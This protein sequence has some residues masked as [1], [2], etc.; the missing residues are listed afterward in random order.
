MKILYI[1]HK[2]L[3]RYFS[4][5]EIYTYSLCR[6]MQRRGHDVLVFCAEDVDAGPDDRIRATDDAYDGIPVHRIFFNRRKTP[7]VVRYSYDNPLVADHCAWFLSLHQPDVVHATSFINVSAAVVDAA[8][9]FGC[10]MLFTATDY[11]CFCPKSIL[12]NHK[13][14][15]CTRPDP[16]ECLAC[17]IELSSLQQRLLKP[18]GISAA[19]TARWCARVSR[20]PVL[21]NNP[22]LKG[23]A[24][25]EARPRYLQ[26]QMHTVDLVIAPN[27]F[28]YKLFLEF[29]VA[30]GRVIHSIYGLN[31]E[32]IHPA[33]NTAANGR[34]R[35]AYIGM[36]GALKGVEL[37]LRSFRPL[38]ASNRAS[39]AVYG[40]DSHFPRYVRGLKQIAQDCPSIAFRGTFPPDRLGE[41]LS[42]I[43][44]LVVP[45]LWYENAPLVIQSAFAAGVPVVG[46]DVPGIAELVTHEANGLLFVRGNQ[47]SLAASLQRFIDEPELLPRLRSGIC[48]PKSIAENGEELEQQYLRLIQNR[49][50]EGKG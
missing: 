17:I 11:W 41:V 36:L 42:E 48:P 20:L 5:T 3:P 39:L 26:R 19:L 10:P 40:D 44:V 33:G 46:A 25:L 16:A 15:L 30:S 21:R 9:A 37:L 1:L 50:K 49:E 8:R 29:G 6:E 12:L 7:D 13:Q 4:G 2:F 45:S 28:M 18:A 32:G 34:I 43:D 35:F 31:T 22:F 47:S 24:S 27:A 23:A 14:E 38:A